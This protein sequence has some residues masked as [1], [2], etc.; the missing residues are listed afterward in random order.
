MD[1]VA[2]KRIPLKHRLEYGLLRALEAL[3]RALPYGACL[4][5]AKGLAWIAFHVARWRRAEAMRRIRQVFPDMP[6]DEAR[7]H[8]W[9]SIETIFLNAAEIMHLNGVTDEWIGGHVSNCREAMG[10]LSA[11]TATTGAILA[12]PHFGNWDLAGIIVAHNGFRIFSVAGVQHNQLTN[13]WMNRKRATGID[14]LSRGSAAL[15]QTMKR[16]KDRQIFAIIPDVRMKTKDIEIDFLGAKANLGRGMALFARKTGSPILVA[17]VRRLSGSRHWLD[18][19]EPIRPDMSLDEDADVL[20]M[21][22]LA[23]AAVERQIRS[24]PGQWFWYN[25]RWVLEPLSD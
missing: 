23:M 25:K 19:G 12:L 22:R 18:V 5:F 20:R 4:K 15:R 17:D 1:P 16:L 7:R 10:K 2:A 13:D 11:A 6:E 3:F 8:L 21:T 9:R 24:D 14:I